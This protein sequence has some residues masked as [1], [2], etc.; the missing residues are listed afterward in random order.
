MP[1]LLVIIFGSISIVLIFFLMFAYFRQRSITK[2]IAVSYANVEIERMAILDR[3]ESVME[4]NESLKLSD[5]VEFIKFLSDSREWAY[6]Y[7]E[8]VQALIEELKES[9]VTGDTDK[10]LAI[11]AK[12]ILMLPEDPETLNKIEGV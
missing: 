2:T 3:L 10:R 5:N 8:E 9:S 12:L 6:N 11:T 4:E 1:D 7:I